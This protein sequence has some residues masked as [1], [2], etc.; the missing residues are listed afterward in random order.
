MSANYCA[1]MKFVLAAVATF[2]TFFSCIDRAVAVEGEPVAIVRNAKGYSIQSMWNLNVSISTSSSVSYDSITFSQS[3]HEN[4]AITIK[5][6]ESTDR[7]DQV[8]DRLANN[9]IADHYD[10]RLR[11][12]R[13]PNH[14]RVQASKRATVITVD[15]LRIAHVHG[16]SSLQ[17]ARELAN[18]IDTVLV[19]NSSEL[20]VKAIAETGCRLVV[21]PKTSDDAVVRQLK[22]NTIAI[23]ATDSPKPQSPRVVSLRSN[24]VELPN[25]LAD[26]IDRKENAS[27][28]SQRVFA[29]LSTQQMN[30]KP[31]NGTHTP[32]WNTEH[33]MGREL[34][35]FSQIF[36]ALDPSIPVMDLN[37]KQMPPEYVAK[38]PKW[39][40]AEEA[41]QLQ[42]VSDFT[43]RF[44]Y[45]LKDLDLDEK[46]PSSFWT[47]RKLLLQMERH[48]SEH[49]ANVK[50]KF[51]LPDWPQ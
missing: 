29:K 7:I 15:G 27:Q 45:L 16:E 46:A 49:T 2:A 33:M 6:D 41:R 39:D 48:Y 31:S 8:F 22:T 44:A 47:P 32:R 11:K 21:M 30:F 43:R 17:S 51:E 28:A 14:I 35:F 36:H 50:K 1:A 12:A 9:E 40:G 23:A 5:V 10:S 26:L 4:H 3:G 24:S 34:L 25:E 38:N 37:P 20:D 42:R 19:A 18:E 13:S